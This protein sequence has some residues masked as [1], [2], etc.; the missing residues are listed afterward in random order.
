MANYKKVLVV[1]LSALGDVAMTVPQ[2]YSV[3]RAYPDITFVMLTQKVASSLFVNAPANLQLHVAQIYDRHKGV[4]GIWRLARELNAMGIDAVVD[5]HD[6]IRTH[7]L[8]FFLRLFG[9]P[10]YIIDKGRV[11]KKLLVARHN[12]R[13]VQLK[14][15]SQRYAEV[16]ARMGLPYTPQF[17]SL[18]DTERGNPE[19]FAHLAPR[20]QD[21][22]TWIGVAPFAKHEGKIYPIDLMEKVVELLSKEENTHVFLF[23]AGEREGKILGAW[24][25]HYSNVTSLADR[26]NGFPVELA[27]ISHLD[28]MVSMDSA[29]MHLA[30]L[31]NVP[32]VSIW[33]ATHR[34][35]GFMG[36][37]VSPHLIV[38]TSLPCRPCSIFGNKPCYRGDYACLHNIKP[39]TIVERVKHAIA[40]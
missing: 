25:D 19:I 13:L 36:Y 12:K 39:E 30:A 10:I 40:D 28:A 2:V 1:R 32:V 31:T 7:F 11:G 37:G 20:K 16:F 8:R 14:T 29:N 35:A 23:G 33:G 34:Y 6:V 4:V 3:C 26:R 38:E 27:I 5:L 24:R 18:Y 9:K 22:E 21:G 15:S 17:N